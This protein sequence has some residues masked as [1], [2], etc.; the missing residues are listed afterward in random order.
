MLLVGCR[1]VRRPARAERVRGKR[2]RRQDSE[3]AGWQLRRRNLAE[4]V[5]AAE[6]YGEED[7]AFGN[8]LSI[9]SRYGDELGA[10]AATLPVGQEKLLWAT[11][12]CRKS[13]N[14]NEKKTPAP[15][16]ARSQAT[17]PGDMFY[18]AMYALKGRENRRAAA[19]LSQL[20][21]VDLGGRPAGAFLQ[22]GAA[23]VTEPPASDA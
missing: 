22:L 21:S 4:S 16:W 11:A 17:S 5:D 8:S 6:M 18:A 19:A 2:A 10:I 3:L 23:I 12:S 14:R 15:K 20:S 13:T 7:E 9:G 1:A